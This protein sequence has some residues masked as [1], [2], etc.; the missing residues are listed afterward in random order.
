MTN[1]WY[2]L[3]FKPNSH[4]LAIKHLNQQGFKTFLPLQNFTSHKTS[5]FTNTNRPLFPGYMFVAFDKD[6][7]QWHK[8]NSTSGVSRLITLNSKLRSVPTG[9]I[10]DLMDRCDASGKLLPAEQF[11]EGNQ[12]KITSGI[13]TNFVATVESLEAHHRISVLINLMGRQTKLT[14]KSNNLQLSN[15]RIS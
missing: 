6:N 15:S 10:N 7:M 4:Q 1:S 8:I 13:F 5:K 2:I 9:L 3:Q 14:I 11:K 12:V